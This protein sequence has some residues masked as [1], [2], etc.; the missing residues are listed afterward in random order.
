MRRRPPPGLRRSRRSRLDVFGDAGRLGDIDA[1]G[2]ETL[3]VEADGVAISASIACTVG[4]VATQ[5]G[6]SGT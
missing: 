6:K 5:P 4:P 1:V 3:D 2:L